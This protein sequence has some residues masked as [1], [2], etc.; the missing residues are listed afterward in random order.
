[1]GIIYSNRISNQ[2]KN[3]SVNKSF[4]TFQYQNLLFHGM[5]NINLMCIYRLQ[6]TSYNL[7]LVELNELLSQQ[8]LRHPLL[9]TGDFNVQFEKSNSK[10][11]RDLIDLT[12]SFG[13]EQFVCGP[14]HKFGHTI[15]LLFANRL[16]FDMGDIEPINYN[17]GDH[18][19]IFFDLPNIAKT[20][21]P[22]KREIKYRD[23]KTLDIPGLASSLSTSLQSAFRDKIDTSSF[24]ELL[25]IYN[26]TVSTEF[27]NH[28]PWKTKTL[29][30]SAESPPWL[31]SEYKA[32]RAARRRLERKW[33]KSGLTEDKKQYVKHR[34]LCAK[35][36]KR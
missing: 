3:C 29:T 28:A 12:S 25:N 6:E 33:K 17:L 23:V 36:F 27:N 20:D 7:F 34:E 31:D 32:N 24:H 11:V 10:Q 14:S 2:V 21:I 13:L 16:D 9:L 8:D 26:E 35:I 19:A 15:D 22:E 30:P 1:M 5:F 4:D 18:F